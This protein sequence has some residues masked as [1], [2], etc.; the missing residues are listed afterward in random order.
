M[1]EATLFILKQ[2]LDD[3]HTSNNALELEAARVFLDQ[4]RGSIQDREF[5]VPIVPFIRLL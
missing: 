5:I 2:I 3:F 4:I 1:Q